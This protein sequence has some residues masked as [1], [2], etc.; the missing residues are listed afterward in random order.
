[1]L[2]HGLEARLHLA[3]NAEA[4]SI[5]QDVRYGLLVIVADRIAQSFAKLE[6][7]NVTL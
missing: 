5:R 4:K 2:V 7:V 6:S 3:I 1:L